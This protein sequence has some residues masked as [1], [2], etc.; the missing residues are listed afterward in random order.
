MNSTEEFANR[1]ASFAAIHKERPT[2]PFARNIHCAVDLDN[3]SSF[4]L[5]I[6][7]ESLAGNAWVC[8]PCSAYGAYAAEEAKRFGHALL[9]WPL[10]ALCNGATAYLRHADLD[11]AVTINNWLLSTNLYPSANH[12]NLTALRDNTIARWPNHAIWFRSLNW[13][14]HFD[15]LQALTAL[16]FQLVASRQVYIVDDV[17]AAT[18]AINFV[19]DQKLLRETKLHAAHDLSDSDYERIATLYALLY[20]NKYST[21]NPQYSAHFLRSWHQTGLLKLH[22]LRDDQGELQAVVG[23]FSLGSILTAPIVGYNTAWPKDLGLYRM[24]MTLAAEQA[25]REGKQINFSAGAAEFKRL[26]GATAETEYS[27]VYSAHLPSNRR[28][29][30]SL[31]HSLTERIGLPIMRRFKL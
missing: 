18:K 14:Q 5:T 31:L 28:R 27:A 9:T 19:R 11:R 8:S 20:T 2:E 16:G 1:A 4:P 21:L 15:W 22:A 3:T 26:R 29:A 24:L 25:L 7:N 6:T 13:R 17:E 23:T 10:V 30:L 12:F